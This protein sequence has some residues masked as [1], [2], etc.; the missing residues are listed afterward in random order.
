VA[1]L[2]A[3]FS[4][5]AKLL[6]PGRRPELEILLEMIALLRLSLSGVAAEQGV[7]ALVNVQ[8]EVLTGH[9]NAGTFPAL[10]VLVIDK[11]PLLHSLVT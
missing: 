6:M 10:K 1:F 7:A 3:R 2:L 11:A 5:P 8:A 9:A 4:R